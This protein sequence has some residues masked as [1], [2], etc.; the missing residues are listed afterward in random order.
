M[1]GRD[2]LP[3]EAV[4][5][6]EKDMVDV[7]GQFGLQPVS[8]IAGMDNQRALEIL[9]R[10]SREPYWKLRYKG[11]CQDVFFLTTLD[12]TPQFVMTMSSLAEAADYPWSD[13][14][15]YIQP[16]HQGV[17]CHCEFNLPFDPG[18]SRET[19]KVNRLYAKCSE[20]LISRGA[21]FSRPYGIW[22]NMVYGRDAQAASLLKGLKGIVD[23]NHILNPGKLCF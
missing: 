23:P 21:Y 18:A 10:P 1:A 19:N 9:S 17:A 6:Q 22:A 2:I 12:R 14:G 16:Q 3:E 15:I 20:E 11:S 8:E 13:V 4:E 5:V 7:A